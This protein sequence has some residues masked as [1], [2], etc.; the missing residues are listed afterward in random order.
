M[1]Y[2]YLYLFILILPCMVTLSGCQVARIAS[3]SQK[4]SYTQMPFEQHKPN[5]H[6]NILFLG[7]ST[8]VGTGARPEDSVAGW[9]AKDFP[10]ADIKNISQNGEKIK[11]LIDKIPDNSKHY[12]LVVLQIGANDIMRL[13]RLKKVKQNLAVAID[14]AKLIGDQMI[15]LHS[16]D[17]GLAPIFIWPLNSI[18]SARSKAFRK[19]YMQMAQTKGVMYVDLL[20]DS[21]HDLFLTDINKYYSPDLLHPSGAGYHFWYDELQKTLK[22]NESVHPIFMNT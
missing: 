16:G 10:E 18:Y 2:T 14:R 17:V 11:D 12:N 9:F 15:M 21:K 19:I 1:K 20:R 8:A 6:L 22:A 5:A 3:L 7:D 4:V 13:T